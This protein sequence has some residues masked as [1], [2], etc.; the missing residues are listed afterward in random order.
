MDPVIELQQATRLKPATTKLAGGIIPLGW[1]SLS[2]D[3]LDDIASRRQW[4]HKLWKITNAQNGACV[5]RYMIFTNYKK[6]TFSKEIG[7]ST[8]VLDYFAWLQL[9]WTPFFGR[10]CGKLSYDVHGWGW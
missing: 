4:T 1:I 3:A 6:V 5:Y 7:K 2:I 8:I 10:D 9:R